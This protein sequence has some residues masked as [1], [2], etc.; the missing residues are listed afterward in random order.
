MRLAEHWDA[1]M[2]GLPDVTQMAVKQRTILL[3][4]HTNITLWFFLVSEMQGQRMIYIKT[5]R[6]REKWSNLQL[7]EQG[8]V[9]MTKRP[10]ATF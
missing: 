5:N 9:F 2:I 1:F 7:A 4:I 6:D 8:N 3:I 10:D